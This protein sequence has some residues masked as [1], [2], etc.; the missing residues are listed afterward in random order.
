MSLWILK[1]AQSLWERLIRSNRLMHNACTFIIFYRLCFSLINRCNLSKSH[2]W[3]FFLHWAVFTILLFWM[4]IIVVLMLSNYFYCRYFKKI[5]IPD[6]DRAHLPLDQSAIN[7]AHA[8][9]T[10]II[11]VSIYMQI[12]WE[13]KKKHQRIRTLLTNSRICLRIYK[14]E[15]WLPRWKH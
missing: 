13:T 8:N 2:A 10:L 3:S 1:T 9:N 11:S 4:L 6:M 14:L 7:V 5:S 12:D 15:H